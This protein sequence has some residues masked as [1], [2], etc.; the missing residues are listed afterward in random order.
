MS[1]DFIVS[2]LHNFN[3]YKK[4][5]AQ[6]LTI[7]PIAIAIIKTNISSQKMR[8]YVKFRKCDTMEL[9]SGAI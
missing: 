1:N 2:H 7:L 3:N 5:Y 4:G 8:N 6:T 9:D